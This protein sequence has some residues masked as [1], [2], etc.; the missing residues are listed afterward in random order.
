MISIDISKNVKLKK[1]FLKGNIYI[2]DNC[3]DNLTQL[4]TLQIRN[5]YY[6]TDIDKLKKLTKLELINSFINYKKPN[7]NNNYNDDYCDDGFVIIYTTE[8]CRRTICNMN[9]L[10]YLFVDLSDYYQ[11]YNIPPISYLLHNTPNLEI[12]IGDESTLIIVDH[13]PIN[14]KPQK[15]KG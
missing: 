1:L 10:K 13:R 14:Y 6:I 7:D 5:N 9:K 3:F 11:R 15:S 4:K 12:I 8:M 2:D